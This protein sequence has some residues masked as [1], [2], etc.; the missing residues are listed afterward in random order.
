V[1]F[2]DICTADPM[3]RDLE[4]IKHRGVNNEDE[5]RNGKLFYNG[6]ERMLDVFAMVNEITCL[7]IQSTLT[8]L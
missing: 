6:S 7:E 5:F 2:R 1:E 8:C 3:A 4:H